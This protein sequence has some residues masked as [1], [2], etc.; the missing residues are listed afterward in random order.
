MAALIYVTE[1]GITYGDAI[2]MTHVDRR[3]YLR[4][5]T[6]YKNREASEYRRVSSSSG[7]RGRKKP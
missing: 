4:K 3:Y 7:S 1:G 5:F 2:E 6:D